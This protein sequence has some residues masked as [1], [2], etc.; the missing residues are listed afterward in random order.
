MT[1]RLFI[2]EDQPLILKNQLKVLAHFNDIHVVGTALSGEDALFELSR[3]DI[4]PHVVLCDLGLPRM[5]GIQVTKR[6]KELN[7]AIEVLIFTV[8]DDDESVLQAIHAGASGY[9]LK[10]TDGKKIYEAIVDV[11]QGGTIIQ[12]KLARRLLKFFSMP[13]SGTP[14]EL[15]D[16]D[17]KR[18]V[19]AKAS[20]T[21]RELECLQIIAKGLSN[22]EA[23]QVLKLS[24]ATIRTH[25][26]HIYQKLD[27]NNRV[28]AITEGI[29]QGIIDL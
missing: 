5:N 27:V 20:L 21:I 25:L 8:F 9:L 6:I 29:R 26:E 12:P 16:K 10:G 17:G 13:L 14:V 15:L 18:H 4:Y 11:H 22:Q 19:D 1:I 23:A 3:R 7:H 2:I 28:E 24:K